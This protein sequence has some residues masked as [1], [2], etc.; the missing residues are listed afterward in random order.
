ML[1]IKQLYWVRWISNLWCS[2]Y[3]LLNKERM[4]MG[5]S[6]N[7]YKLNGYLFIL[8]IF[9]VGWN[10]ASGEIYDKLHTWIAI[11]VY[12]KD[13]RVGYW[14]C[15]NIEKPGWFLNRN[16]IDYFVDLYY[17]GDNWEEYKANINRS[18]NLKRI[19]L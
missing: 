16:I 19:L 7:L 17:K 4:E 1:N 11:N 8:S 10:D 5:D 12:N 14:Y 3:I 6:K 15:E 9:D 2:V 13:S 18:R